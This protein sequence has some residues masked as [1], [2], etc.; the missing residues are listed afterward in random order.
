MLLPDK[1]GLNMQMRDAVLRQLQRYWKRE[2]VMPSREAIV[3]CAALRSMTA[4][5]C[6]HGSDATDRQR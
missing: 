4:I 5:V 2:F 3:G 1:F 6:S